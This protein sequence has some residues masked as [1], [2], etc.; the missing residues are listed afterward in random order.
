MLGLPTSTEIRKI[1][2]KK[3]VYAQF[4]AE[5]SAER[6][7]KFDADI[8]RMVLTNE[9][10]PVSVN[11][12][13]G[14]AVQSFFVLQVFLKEKDFDPQNIAWLARLFGQRLVM[15]LEAEGCQRLAVWQTHLIM[16]DWAEPGAMTLPLKG[17]DLDKVWENL[18]AQIAGI[19]RERDRTLDEQLALAAQREKLQKEI[20]RLEKKARAERQPKKKFELVQQMHALKRELEDTHNG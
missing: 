15:V 14:E 13:A 3:K 4:G 1:I 16:T 17:L 11:L 20:A 7:K 10:S 6:R 5:M 2:T 12:P 18:V 9:V 8:A 19:E